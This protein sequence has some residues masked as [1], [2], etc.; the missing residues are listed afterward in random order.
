MGLLER[1]SDECSPHALWECIHGRSSLT[2][3]LKPARR[4][5]PEVLGCKNGQDLG[6][7]NSPSDV[8]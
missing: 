8:G 6:L 3:L 1:H 7:K 4:D 5:V 2:P